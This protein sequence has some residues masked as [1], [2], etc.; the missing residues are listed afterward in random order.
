MSG[1]KIVNIET[2]EFQKENIE[3]R[4]EGHRARALEKAFTRDPSESAIK[5]IE[6]TK[7]SY[8]EAIQNTGTTDDPLEPWLKYIQW[9]LE[10]FPQGD[11]NVSEFVRL[12]ERCTQHFLKDPLYQ[13]DIRYLKV[14]LRYA[15]YTNDPAELFSFLEVHKIGLQFSIYY[16]E[17]ANYF[18]SKGL[19]AKALSIY[20]RGQERHARPAL[21]FEERRR[22][23]LYRC[24]EKAPDCLKEQTLPETALQIKFENTLSLGSDSSSSSTLS[25]HAA[26][27]F[28]KPVQ[29][30]ITVFSDASGDPSS[31]LDTAWEQF[32]S[33]AVR[34]KENT[35]SATPW[36]GVTLP[37]KSRKSTTSHKLHVY[38]DEQIPLQQTLPPTMEE[39][40]KSGVNFAFHV[41]DCYPQGPHGI[42]LSPEEVRAK[43]YIT[44]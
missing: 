18:E 25:S 9:T 42:E 6:A 29:K 21:R 4:R 44:F 12:L 41:H 32:G 22:E 27:H 20:N 13:N 10:T 1:S 17:Y 24:M 2:I 38:R 36:V 35:I 43:K 28:R 15:P 34:R 39:D 31:T 30:R 37:I 5:D 3:P 26:A 14:W 7:Q 19:Y 8:E 40:A 23:F 33:R 11:S 16:E